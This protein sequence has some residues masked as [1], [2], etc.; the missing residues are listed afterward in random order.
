MKTLKLFLVFALFLTE[1]GVSAQPVSIVTEESS[2][3]IIPG[4]CTFDATPK[5]HDAVDPSGYGN[6]AAINIYDAEF[7]V[8]ATINYEPEKYLSYQH[9]H[10]DL[11]WSIDAPLLVVSESYSAI[12][13]IPMRFFD[14]RQCQFLGDSHSEVVFTQTLFNDDDKYEY[15]VP[16]YRL[17]E[18][19][20][21][22][23]PDVTGP[24]QDVYYNCTMYTTGLEVRTQD[25]TVVYSLDFVREYEDE[26][27]LIVIFWEGKMY[28]GVENPDNYGESCDL[29]LINNVNS[30]V[31]LEKVSVPNGMKLFPSVT[32][33]N[34]MVTVDLGDKLN[35]KDGMIFVTDANGKTVYTQ[36]VD[37][38]VHSTQIP[39]SRLASGLYIVSLKTPDC[40]YETAKLII[41]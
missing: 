3:S 41:R 36:E 15:I 17:K 1:I 23:I 4:V 35:G 25:G 2:L 32:R 19:R 34:T 9:L 40:N 16:K 13:W 26:V 27:N 30:D 28:L 7:D 37:A 12:N 29:Y 18:E 5:I 38:D 24:V 33:K 6:N 31:R 10:A 8:V 11:N 20:E 39:T 14:L 21:E 22:I